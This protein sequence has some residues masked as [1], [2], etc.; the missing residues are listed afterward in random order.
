MFSEVESRRA[1]SK[2][3]NYHRNRYMPF[4]VDSNKSTIVPLKIYS[5]KEG[6]KR[7][8]DI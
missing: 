3:L 7:N 2:V 8:I 1:S 5:H 6:S 4:C